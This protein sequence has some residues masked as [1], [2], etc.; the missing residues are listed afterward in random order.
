MIVCVPPLNA[1]AVYVTVQ[2]EVL[3]DPTWV[4]VHGL[5]VKLPAPLLLKPT[6][7]C[8]HDFVPESVSETSTVQVVAD[9]LI[10]TDPGE[11]PVTLVEVDRF[12]TV[13]VFPAASA[14]SACTPSFAV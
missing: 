12:V 8:G 6:V 14:L 2:L 9:P 4:S 7:P 11:Q 3:V 1:V 13:N 10:V 5:P